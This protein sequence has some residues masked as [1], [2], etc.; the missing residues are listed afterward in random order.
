MTIRRRRTAPALRPP[1]ALRVTESELSDEGPGDGGFLARYERGG[2]TVAVHAV[3]RPRP[4]T[5]ARRALGRTVE[6]ATT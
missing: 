5:R 1:P 2:T 4:F 3:D 6:T